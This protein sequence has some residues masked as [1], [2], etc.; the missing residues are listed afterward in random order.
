L[1][2]AQQGDAVDVLTYGAWQRHGRQVRRGER[3][4]TILAPVV[5]K[6]EN[7]DKPE[8]STSVLTSF[9]AHAVFSGEQTQRMVGPN[10]RDLPE[11]VKI[12]KDIESAECFDRSV[13]VLRDVLLGLGPQV[14]SAVE[15]RA[16][17]SGDCSGAGGWYEPM[18][19]RI[20]VI[21]GEKSRAQQFKTLV[22]EAAHS[23]LHPSGDH[24]S[25]DAKE[26]EAESVAFIVC[27][28]VGGLDTSAYSFPYVSFWAGEKD[29]AKMILA[30]G[31]RIV[32]A[33]NTILDVLLGANVDAEV[34]EVA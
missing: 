21:T 24:H 22:H 5:V 28:V 4:I 2:R 25:T 7:K 3:A 26:V 1:V 8:E 6:R 13:E 20:V 16:R 11:S 30:S 10:G 17:R 27:S 29:A 14:V 34:D 19:K 31:Q 33:V 18:N 23:L 12:T 15:L 9:R 32:G